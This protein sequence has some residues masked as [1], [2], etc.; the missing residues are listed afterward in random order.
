MYI[1]VPLYELN[2]KREVFYFMKYECKIGFYKCAS[3][4]TWFECLITCK[5][6]NVPS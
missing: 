3:G 1:Y 5:K 2:A 4:V 6:S